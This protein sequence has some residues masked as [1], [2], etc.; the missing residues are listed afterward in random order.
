[1]KVN[2]KDNFDTI[3]KINVNLF[4]GYTIDELA[5]VFGKIN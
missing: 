4:I 5:D 2:E 3:V 1:M